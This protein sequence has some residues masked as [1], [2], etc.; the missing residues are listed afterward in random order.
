M[1]S[2]DTPPSWW[3]PGVLRGWMWALALARRGRRDGIR[4]EV[5]RYSTR[6]WEGGAPVDDTRRAVDDLARR[7]PGRRIGVLGYSMGG[8]AALLAADDARISAMVTAAAWVAPA[9]PPRIRPHHRLRV[10]LQ[11]GLHDTITGTRSSVMAAD[12]LRRQGI[13]PELLIDVPDRH[14]MLLRAGLWHRASYD[15]LRRG[16]LDPPEG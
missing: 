14:A 16:L 10:L 15:F 9:D 6:G 13:R 5:M 8:R 3:E 4:V 1:P 2:G 7:F 12:R 11:H